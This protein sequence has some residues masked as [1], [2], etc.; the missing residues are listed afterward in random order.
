MIIIDN[1]NVGKWADKKKVSYTTFSDLSQKPEVYGLV[2][3][4]IA[5]INAALPAGCRLRKFVN[6]H[7]EFDADEFELTRN[8]KLRRGYLAERYRELIRAIYSDKKDISIEAQ[9][10]YT[11]GRTG[12]LKTSVQ[13]M[14][15][16][17]VSK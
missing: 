2:K 6:L 1:N 9:F 11:D 8:R 16:E 13:I 7:K 12:V 10:S 5:K 4:E 15:V 17:E 14:D 3:Q